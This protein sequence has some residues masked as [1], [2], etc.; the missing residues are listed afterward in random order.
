MFFCFFSMCCWLLFFVVVL[1]CFFLEVAIV[2]DLVL[3][4]KFNGSKMRSLIM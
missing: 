2:S 4:N 1:G 3:L